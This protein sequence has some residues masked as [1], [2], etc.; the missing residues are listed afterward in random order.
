MSFRSWLLGERAERAMYTRTSGNL[1]LG[2]PDAGINP[3]DQ[4][5]V[6]WWQGSDAG[7][8]QFPI[9]PNGPWTTGSALPVVVRAVSLI[10]GPLSSAPY[11]VLNGP[12]AGQPLPRPRWL[13]DPMLKRPDSRFVSDVYP[14]VVE[15]T[16]YGFWSEFVR[17]AVLWGMGVFLCTEDADGMPAAGT[18]KL[19]HPWLLT[20]ETDDAG[21]LHWVLGS[22][23][24]DPAEKAVFD[25]NGRISF[26]DI[27]YRVVVLRNPHSSVSEEGYSQGVF[28]MAPS[29]FG[30]ADQI[31]TFESGVFRSGIPA[32]FLQVQTPGLSPESAAELKSAWMAAHGGDRRSVAVLNATTTF[33]PL[34]MSPVDAALGEVKRLNLAEI[35]FAF[36]LSPETL[37]VSLTGSMTYSNTRDAWVNHRDYALSPWISALQDTLSALLPGSQSVVVNLDAFA[38]PSLKERMDGYAV[39]I[40]AG[41]MEPNECRELE[42]LEPLPEKKPE[43]VPP[44]FL[45]QQQEPPPAVEEPPP[46]EDTTVRSIR[47]Q[48]WR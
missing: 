11:R 20:T 17:N 14:E 43:P 6:I 29:A 15:L 8:G 19:V 12:V 3:S 2:G 34:N 42:G 39:A 5:P 31:G 13:L 45:A 18:L 16:R 4:S 27:T 23:A 9:G 40:N 47:R 35:A 21:A 46:E 44:E 28:E 1:L 32:G 38:N 24:A 37:G 26:G 10:T 22:D 30:M 33:T 7:G 48:P 41:V 36:G 25:R